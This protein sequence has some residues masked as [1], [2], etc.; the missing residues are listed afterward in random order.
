MQKRIWDA[1]F[2]E[3]N[4][5]SSEKGDLKTR[6]EKGSKSRKVEGRTDIT[7]EKPL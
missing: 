6:V 1:L 7:E 3:L 2:I 5:K 4:K